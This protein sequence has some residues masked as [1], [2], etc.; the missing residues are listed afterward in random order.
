MTIDFA[1]LF[2]ECFSLGFGITSFAAVVGMAIRGIK[3]IFKSC[4]DVQGE[5]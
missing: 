5:F 1:G 3:S 4:A 2:G